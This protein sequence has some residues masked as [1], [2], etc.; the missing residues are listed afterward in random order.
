MRR[1]ISI[2][3][4]ILSGLLIAAHFLRSGSLLVVGLA[5]LF[6]FLLFTGR[7]WAARLVQLLLVVSAVEWVRT[8]ISIAQRRRSAG[9]P[10]TRMAAILGGVALF[11]LASAWLIQARKRDQAEDPRSEDGHADIKTA[12][13]SD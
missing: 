13:A 11:T 8:L 2:A 1:G 4:A 6:P 9:E 10:W 3:M 12:S 5:V 7:L